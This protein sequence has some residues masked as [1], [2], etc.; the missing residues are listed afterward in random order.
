M[1][2]KYKLVFRGEVAEGQHPAVVKKRLGGLLKL[3]DD[4]LE[5]L[6]SGKPV[7]LKKSADEA[8]AVKFQAAFKKAGARLRVLEAEDE[9]PPGAVS[10]PEAADESPS[11]PTAEPE[12]APSARGADAMAVA[13]VG[14]DLL[15]AAERQPDVVADVETEHIKLQGAVFSTPDEPEPGPAGPDVSHLDIAEPGVRLGPED[16]AVPAVE[17]DPDFD[18]AEVGVV[19]VEGSEVEPV[20]DVDS[21]DFD[22]AP[23][24]EDLLE[25]G[26]SEAPPAPD[27]SHIK[28]ED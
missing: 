25:R 14:E 16:E 21:V 13:A 9:D 5:A 27:T 28:L 22:V 2:D 1:A 12:A 19:L 18:I 4:R 7:V 23:P 26:E 11:T 20:I 6:F 24:G 10:E 8:M 17:L 3:A 15:S